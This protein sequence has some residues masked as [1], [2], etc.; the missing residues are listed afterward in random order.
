MDVLLAKCSSNKISY[1]K[2]IRLN[3]AY[4]VSES[5]AKSAYFQLQTRLKPAVFL[6]WHSLRALREME[7]TWYY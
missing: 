5:L 6:V 2:R 4:H 3:S 1:E 7:E